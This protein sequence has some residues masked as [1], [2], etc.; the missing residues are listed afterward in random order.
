MHQSMI[1]TTR[2]ST[3]LRRGRSLACV[4]VLGHGNDGY[5]FSIPGLKSKFTTVSVCN[6]RSN[7]AW[8]ASLSAISNPQS[9]PSLKRT[10]DSDCVPII[11]NWTC[12]NVRQLSKWMNSA[13]CGEIINPQKI[14]RLSVRRSVTTLRNQ[15]FHWDLLSYSMHILART[16]RAARHYQ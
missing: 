10:V 9:S 1:P 5:L 14:V 4:P 16:A 2:S 11:E 7:A 6:I 15:F 13:S 12:F 8:K 3:L